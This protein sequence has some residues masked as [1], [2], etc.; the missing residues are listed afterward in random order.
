MIYLLVTGG[1][2][3]SRPPAFASLY[4]PT[5]VPPLTSGQVLSHWTQEAV[6]VGVNYGEAVLPKGGRDIEDLAPGTGCV[7]QRGLRKVAAYRDEQG[8]LHTFSAI[9]PHMFCQVRNGYC[10]ACCACTAA[11]PQVRWNPVDTTFDC[12]CH[13][14]QFDRYGRVFNG[15][16]CAD[17]PRLE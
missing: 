8:G 1:S 16:S 12:S 3:L 14:S 4:A 11:F 7:T 9:C 2:I 13:G 10:L 17:L 6:N 5:R 15:P